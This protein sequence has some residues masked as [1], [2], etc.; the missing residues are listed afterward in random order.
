LFPPQKQKVQQVLPYKP[1]KPNSIQSTDDQHD[2]NAMDNKART[3]TLKDVQIKPWKAPSWT[4][5]NK[6]A[7]IDNDEYDDLGLE[8]DCKSS[9]FGP[10]R[11][12]LIYR[13]QCKTW[14]LASLIKR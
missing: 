8:E 9:L 5:L 11:T 10:P 13:L 14:I 7:I 1:V 4:S 2:L 3:Q 12:F 6:E